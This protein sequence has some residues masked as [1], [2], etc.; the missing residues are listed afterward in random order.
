MAAANAETLQALQR[1]PGVTV[2]LR[3]WT[4]VARQVW[5]G[6]LGAG[7]PRGARVS[8]SVFPIYNITFAKY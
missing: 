7:A 2:T 1:R 3:V 4:Q 8:S 6:P 5:C